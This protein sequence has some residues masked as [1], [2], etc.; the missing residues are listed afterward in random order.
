M[1]GWE[2]RVD[3]LLRWRLDDMAGY[4]PPAAGA[5]LWSVRV[6]FT[7]AASFLADI[8]EAKRAFADVAPDALIVPPLYG[9]KQ[10]REVGAADDDEGGEPLHA[11]GMTVYAGR[12]AIERLLAQ[13]PD[14]DEEADERR[15]GIRAVTVGRRITGDLGGDEPR[16]DP[17]PDAGGDTDA[18]TRWNAPA[19][20]DGPAGGGAGGAPR[21]IVA[22]IDDGIALG[23]ELFRDAAGGTRIEHAWIMADRDGNRGAPGTRRGRELTKAEIDA[24]LV[25]NAS[26]GDPGTGVLDEAGFQRDLGILDFSRGVHFETAFR[27]AHGTHVLSLAAGRPPGEDDGRLPIIAV[28]LPAT[29]TEATG[30]DELLPDLALAIDF[31]LEKARDI[32]R[33]SGCRGLPLVLNFSYG[34]FA[35]AHDGTDPIAALLTRLATSRRRQIRVVVPAGNGNLAQAHAVLR[36]PP[37]PTSG[38][39]PDARVSIHWRVQPDDKTASFLHFWLPRRPS[40]AA[41]RRVLAAARVITPSG[42]TVTL[43]LGQTPGPRAI[44]LVRDG[45]VFGR[46]ALHHVAG[47]TGRGRLTLMIKPTAHEEARPDL[48]PH[49]LWQVVLEPGEITPDEVIHAR[50][51][52]DDSLPNYPLRGR[53]SYFED[54]AYMR[55]DA[56][57]RPLTVDPAAPASPI[58]RAGTLSPFATGDAPNGVIV[59][60]GWTRRSGEM[61]AY[62]SGGPATAPSTRRGPDAALVAEDSLVQGGVIGAGSQSGSMV[63]MNGTSVAAPQL[64]RWLALRLLDGGSADRQAVGQE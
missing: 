32:D 17:T 55:F 43:A 42:Q 20:Q 53:Q 11:G 14:A 6:E 1:T 10:T 61:A 62:S 9:S 23:H 5:E 29:V 26:G 40:A 46:L 59:A 54:A 18:E 25:A 36:F 12:A 30:G 58:R 48:A 27:R 31:I 39:A 47:G 35:G 24:A 33:R 41:T 34:T 52:R 3:P 56:L 28:Q 50:I 21:V 49:G 22:V 57:G 16:G 13:L 37:A 2:D 64:A 51:Q 38:C 7:G 63:A 8:G 60:G 44:D 4:Y 15:T 45:Q 19:G